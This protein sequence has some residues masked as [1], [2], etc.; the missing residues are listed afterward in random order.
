MNPINGNTGDWFEIGT[1]APNII[2]QNQSSKLLIWRR[3][4]AKPDKSEKLG[5]ELES[6]LALSIPVVGQLFGRFVDPNVPEGVG[7]RV[8]WEEV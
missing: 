7:L 5:F 4:A 1:G 2:F 6:S 8:I 3:Q